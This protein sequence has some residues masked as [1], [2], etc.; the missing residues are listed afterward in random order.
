MVSPRSGAGSGDAADDEEVLHGHGAQQPHGPTWSELADAASAALSQLL[1][2][3]ATALSRPNRRAMANNLRVF[4]AQG[5]AGP[6]TM[7]PRNVAI[8]GV[9]LLALLL[10]VTSLRS[11]PAAVKLAALEQKL[12]LLEQKEAQTRLALAQEVQ[13]AMASDLSTML[14]SSKVLGGGAR[15]FPPV[16]RLVRGPVRA[17][18]CVW[19]GALR[20]LRGAPHS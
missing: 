18:V 12:Y 5:G 19:G 6:H 2:A 11:D 13:K 8:G 1:A 7:N 10:V 17:R 15:A 16:L 20:L 9:A 3:L 14:S 4:A